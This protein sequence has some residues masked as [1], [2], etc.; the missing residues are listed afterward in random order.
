MKITDPVEFRKNNTTLLDRFIQNEKKSKNLEISIYNFSIKTATEK[1]VLKKWEN[2]RFIKI[3]MNQLR[4]IYLNLNPKNYIG[5]NYLLEKITKENTRFVIKVGHMS[6][7][8]LFPEKWRKMIEK[9]IK[10]MENFEN[11]DFSS[12]SSEFKCFKCKKRNCTYYQ[13]QTRSADEPM[14]TFIQCLECGNNWKQ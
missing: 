5:N 2:P 8:E 4:T 11:F 7:Q 9:K 10:Q 3:Y 14:T 13:L 12:A 1:N 6:H